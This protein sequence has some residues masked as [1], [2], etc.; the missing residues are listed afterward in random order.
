M[1]RGSFSAAAMANR[2]SLLDAGLDVS[3]TGNGGSLLSDALLSGL[4]AGRATSA[5]ARM[6]SSEI[7]LCA[8]TAVDGESSVSSTLSPNPKP[9]VVVTW[10]SGS[11][12][13]AARISSGSSGGQTVRSRFRQTARQQPTVRFCAFPGL[14]ILEFAPGRRPAG[15]LV[16]SEVLSEKALGRLRNG[17]NLCILVFAR[18]AVAI[19]NSIFPNREILK[20]LLG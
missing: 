7:S 16:L 11:A 14:R 5:A 19:G 3:L 18:S 15:R 13:N 2:D 17:T 12:R 9:L 20:T 10:A 6:S 4:E 1:R 8:S